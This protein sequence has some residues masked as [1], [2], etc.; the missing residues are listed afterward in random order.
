MKRNRTYLGLA[1]LALLL[2]REAGIFHLTV[3]Y[4]TRA[5]RTTWWE[6]EVEGVYGVPSGVPRSGS[7][8]VK[9]SRG[10]ERLD[11]LWIDGEGQPRILTAEVRDERIGGLWWLP[12]W[13]PVSGSWK[14]V[15][16]D[17]DGHEVGTV[18][19]KAELGFVGVVSASYARECVREELREDLPGDL[20]SMLQI[21][22]EPPLNGA[23]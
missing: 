22:R 21:P 19:C 6:N 12:I 20:L 13:K 15:V 5:T 9:L 3:H 11:D 8:R 18:S 1:V 17:E 23:P 10:G 2:I 4:R 14:C 7:L 16:S